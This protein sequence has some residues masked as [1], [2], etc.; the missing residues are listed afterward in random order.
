MSFDRIAS[1]YRFLEWMAFCNTLQ[2]ARTAFVPQVADS[3]RA[4]VVG[5]GDGRFLADLLRRNP[6]IHVDYADASGKMLRLAR[7]RTAVISSKARDLASVHK[8][9]RRS[10]GPSRTGVVY[11]PRDDTSPHFNE[12]LRVKFHHADFL[13]WVP[14]E[15][16]YDLVVTHFFLDC[17]DRDRLSHV[18]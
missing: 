10:L 12:P 18:I 5:E 16:P 1:S 7:W 2:R 14:P 15:E 8:R 9:F 13:R 4:L 17:F 6:R 3:R 11:A